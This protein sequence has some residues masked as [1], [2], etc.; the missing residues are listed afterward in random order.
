MDQKIQFL[1][2][3]RI[4]IIYTIII[5]A[6]S[7]LLLCEELTVFFNP[8]RNIIELCIKKSHRKL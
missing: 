7:M 5:N 3:Y 6:F 8:L 4:N 2:E 1:N